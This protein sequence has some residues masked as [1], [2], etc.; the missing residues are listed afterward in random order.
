MRTEDLIADLA[1]RMTPVRPLPSPGIRTL[2]WLAVAAAC[3]MAAV[4]LLGARSDVLLRL[5]QP[6][7]L[8]VAMLALL[9]S[10]FAVVVTLVLAIPGAERTPL[11]RW[12]TLGLLG[13]WAVTMAWLVLDAGRGLPLSTD[14]HWPVCLLR[15]VLIGVVP[16]IALTTM[17]RR[18][19]PLRPGW[20]AGLAA[21][22]AA[23][24]GALAVQIIC[25]LDDPGHAFL[26]HFVPV[27]MMMGLGLLA[28]RAMTR[29]IAG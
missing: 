19:T 22:A 21:V 6:D 23:S 14:Q 29:R 13:A 4:T 15:V 28:R 3:G 16:A 11:G 24:M 25:P 12:S 1:G 9:T 2:A 18:A 10:L 27:I 26:G 5:T 8:G 20:A 17:V 7:Y